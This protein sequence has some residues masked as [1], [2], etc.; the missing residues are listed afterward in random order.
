[1]AQQ[2]FIFR[3]SGSSVPWT[4]VNTNNG[5]KVELSIDDYGDIIFSND[6]ILLGYQ[7]TTGTVNYVFVITG[8]DY[9]NTGES[10]TLT[11][12]EIF[13]QATGVPFDL[14]T[15]SGLGANDLCEIDRD[16]YNRIVSQFGV[17]TGSSMASSSN[18]NWYQR[19]YM[20]APGTGKT[21]EAEDLAQNIIKASSNDIFRTTFHPATD[22]AS[23]VG[24]YKPESYEDPQ[25][26]GKYLVKYTFSEQPFIQAYRKAWEYKFNGQN[27]PVVLIIEEIN[28]ANCAQAFGDIFQLLDRVSA[29]A[30]TPEKSL[31]DYLKTYYS[32]SLD[33]DERM[34]LPDNLSILATMNTSDQSL[35]PIDSAF[36]RRWER[37]YI[38]IDY[39]G[40]T[41]SQNIP[42]I[43]LSN[44][45]KSANLIM[46]FG[47]RSF[48]WI[49]FLFR[50]NEK[51]SAV[52]MDEKKLGNYAIK[53]NIKTK[54]FVGGI[55]SYLWEGVC[56][57]LDI[58][59]DNYFLK[60]KDAQKNTTSF[61]F[62]DIVDLAEADQDVTLQEFMD[63]L[64]VPEIPSMVLSTIPGFTISSA[65]VS[66][67]SAPVSPASS[68]T[69]ASPATPGPTV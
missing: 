52:Q 54:Q 50:V 30:I 33:T 43:D 3:I 58:E 8:I 40:V 13:L 47:T 61:K 39:T 21:T 57:D 63:Y 20:G 6:D 64:D 36:L 35:F 41:P 44:L 69:P 23:F 5:L 45:K 27:S 56:K 59:D 62:W 42:S 37:V 16:T 60:K 18:G 55:L 11:L 66:T 48:K 29:S 12:H 15:L 28:R 67:P 31:K 26:K 34:N 14:S 46:T 32:Y 19:I 65:T 68:P 51:I 7:V 38:K 9:S 22:Y 17:S 24:C 1:M 25:M 4:C 2:F 49:D 10:I 53:E